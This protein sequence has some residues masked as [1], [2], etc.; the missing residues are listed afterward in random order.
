MQLAL[1]PAT[2][3]ALDGLACELLIV[4]SFVDDRPPRGLAGLLDWRLNGWLSR[5]VLE[6]RFSGE[7]GELLLF[8][9]GHRVGPQRV[10]LLGLGPQAAFDEARLGE[11]LHLCWS[12]IGRM[13]MKDAALCLLCGPLPEL[14]KRRLLPLLASGVRRLGEGGGAAALR[15]LTLVAA[16]EDLK[17]LQGGLES[18]RGRGSTSDLPASSGTG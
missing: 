15:K 11:A 18:E 9:A 8:P 13:R 7:L 14:P 3:P 10:V 16:A 4:G 6:G 1:V 12:V 5:L 17:V 2:L